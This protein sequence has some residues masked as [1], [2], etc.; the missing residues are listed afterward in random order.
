MAESISGVVINEILPSPTGGVGFDTN[1]DGLVEIVEDQ[2]I[3]LFN[4]SGV[5]VDISGWTIDFGIDAGGSFTFP[6][7]T[8][9]A[10]E[11]V[12]VLGEIGT[13]TAP[14]YLDGLPL[15]AGVANEV[16]L[17][18]G[19]T[20]S[21]SATFGGFA[22]TETDTDDF[23]AQTDGESLERVPDGSDTIV[24]GIP[25]PK[26]FLTG[27]LIL[28]ANGYK[29]VEELE[30]GEK[31][32]TAEG[33]LEEIKWIGHQTIN[34]EQ[35]VNPLRGNPI[36]IKAGALGDNLPFRDLYVSPD[37]S[38]F[39]DGLLINAG[40]LVNDIS[41]VKT[42]PTETFIYHHVELEK[43]SLLISEG[44][45]SESYLPQKENRDEFDNFAEFDALYPNGNNL[46]LWPMDYP[47]ISSWNKV[48]RFVS[49]KLLKIA[50]QLM[51]QES[52]LS[53]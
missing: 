16:I 45:A 25:N 39:V 27:T 38:M 21:I 51:E 22:A 19:G 36:Q 10:G 52:Q 18:D 14:C 53:A 37:H 43:H 9:P 34:P 17:S 30:I 29:P 32:Q 20:N 41:I 2:F 23:G 50:H 4:T 28:T 44:A 49:K 6:S 42:E 48:P 12:V 46:M 35:I 24:S 8:L 40:A 7:Y 13:L 5:D 3:E 26:C 47:R 1:Q 33:S 11:H 31:V 15:F